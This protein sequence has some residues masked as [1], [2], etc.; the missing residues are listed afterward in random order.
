MK[1]HING[2]KN[3]LDHLIQ[4]FC[5]SNLTREIGGLKLASTINIVLQAN[6]LTKCVEKNYETLNKGNKNFPFLILL[7]HN[8]VTPK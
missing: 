2:L 8:F 5:Y 4:G 1:D 6:R 7:P 3:G